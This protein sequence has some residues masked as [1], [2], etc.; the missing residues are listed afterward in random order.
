MGCNQREKTGNCGHPICPHKDKSGY[1][2]VELA[3]LEGNTY[4]E[5]GEGCIEQCSYSWVKG[6]PEANKALIAF[7]LMFPIGD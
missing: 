2:C 3:H 1:E 4:C 7:E 5:V 6:T